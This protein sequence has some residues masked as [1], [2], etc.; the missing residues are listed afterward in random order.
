MSRLGSLIILLALELTSCSLF[1]HTPSPRDVKAVGAGEYVVYY[2]WP[3]VVTRFGRDRL[4]AVPAFMREHGLIPQ[5][6]DQ[7]V[8]L[9]C[10]GEGEAGNGW[11]S[12]Y[13][14]GGPAPSASGNQKC[15][16]R[17]WRQMPPL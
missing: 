16:D 7:G 5:A 3:A 9:T 11:A 1:S 13:C 10:G 14:K 6:C 8:E 17:D 2:K 4:T 12:F 15:G